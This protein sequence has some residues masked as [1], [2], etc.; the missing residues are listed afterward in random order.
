MC[1]RDSFCSAFAHFSRNN[2]SLRSPIVDSQQQSAWCAPVSRLIQT[3]RPRQRAP[4]SHGPLASISRGQLVA[5]ITSGLPNLPAWHRFL[6]VLLRLRASQLTDSRIHVAVSRVA[7]SSPIARSRADESK[8]LASPSRGQPTIYT[9]FTR[10]SRVLPA[11]AVCLALLSIAL[12]DKR[13]HA[14]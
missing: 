4:A 14:A 3:Q 12:A 6:H 2:S 7:E 13:V 10:L 9:C 11:E 5:H 8:R 1:I